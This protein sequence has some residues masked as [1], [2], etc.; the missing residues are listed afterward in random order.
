MS[1]HDSKREFVRLITK[2]ERMLYGYVLSLVPQAADADEIVQET[3]L[4]L[5]DEF[6]KFIPGSSFAAWSLKVAHY[7]VLTWR[8]KSHRSKLIF[9]DSLVAALAEES[10]TLEHSVGPRYEALVECVQ[11]MSATSQRLLAECY[12]GNRKIKEVAEKLSRT[13]ASVYKA[14][15]RL[16]AALFDCIER[17]LG[18]QVGR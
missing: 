9:D 4:R 7:Q 8:K 16:R 11:Q 15:E 10:A 6:D 13:E 2:H 18:K 17:K 3:N 1:S 12:A 5:W 14:L